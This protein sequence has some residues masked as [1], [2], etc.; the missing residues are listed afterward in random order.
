MVTLNLRDVPLGRNSLQK[1]TL[2]EGQSDERLG[3]VSQLLHFI[4]ILEYTILN[5][6]IANYSL[7][8]II[9]MDELTL[10]EDKLAYFFR[11][12]SYYVPLYL[13]A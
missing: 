6:T 7:T 10:Y 8:K 9:L 12:R 13:N 11:K 5:G 3:S 2:F 4:V 1:M